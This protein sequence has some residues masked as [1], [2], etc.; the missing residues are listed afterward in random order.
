MKLSRKQYKPNHQLNIA[1]LVDVV[2][3]LI[4]FFMMVSQFSRAE[5]EPLSLPQAAQGDVSE[6]DPGGKITVNV[7]S[8]GEIIIENQ[9]YNLEALGAFLQKKLAAASTAP[10]TV[11]IRA[12]KNAAWKEVRRVMNICRK[13]SIHSVKAAVINEDK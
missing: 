3:L 6:I 7:R 12:D 13:H 4:A 5:V 1:P 11:Y 9:T 8:S 2:F 10:P